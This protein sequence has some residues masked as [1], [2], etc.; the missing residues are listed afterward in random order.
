MDQARRA[1]DEFVSVSY[2]TTD[3]RWRLL[4]CVCTGTATL[5]WKRKHPFRTRVL[6]ETLPSR[7]FQIN[8]V[9]CQPVHDEATSSQ[10]TVLVVICGTE[11]SEVTKERHFRS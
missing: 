10:T 7:E 3:T 11:K 6:L 4:S 9:N 1:S 2:T 8:T 5:M